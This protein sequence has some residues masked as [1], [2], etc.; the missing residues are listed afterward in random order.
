MALNYGFNSLLMK[1][2]MQACIGHKFEM[3]SIIKFDWLLHTSDD[4]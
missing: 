3:Y 4:S 1:E 2:Y